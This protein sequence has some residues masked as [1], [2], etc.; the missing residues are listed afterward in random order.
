MSSI[1]LV[2]VDVPAAVDRNTSWIPAVWYSST[3]VITLLPRTSYTC[4]VC[5]PGAGE[6]HPIVVLGLK[7]LW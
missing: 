6:Y 7:G 4:R 3:K 1:C 2:A 5:W